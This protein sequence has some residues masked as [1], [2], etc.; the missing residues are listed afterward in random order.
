MSTPRPR[1]SAPQ[2]PPTSHG[3]ERETPTHAHALV[4][5]V[6][7]SPCPVPTARKG[8]DPAMSSAG[9]LGQAA[10]RRLGRSGRHHDRLTD[11]FPT[12]HGRVHTTAPARRRPRPASGGAYSYATRGRCSLTPFPLPGA[13]APS[14][15]CPVASAFVTS[16]VV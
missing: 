4:F 1:G 16:S 13:A 12:G 6:P 14:R 9:P 8:R 11:A 10:S 15:P 7:A 2:P 3:Q 5:A